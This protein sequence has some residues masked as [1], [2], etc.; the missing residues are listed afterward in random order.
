MGLDFGV[1]VNPEFLRE[2]A[3]LTDF[4]SPD[5][6]V[7]GEFDRKSGD[8]LETLYKEFHRPVIRCT[9]EEAELVKYASNGFLATQISYF[10]EVHALCEKLGL[11]SQVVSQA[12]SLDMRIGRYGVEGG[13]PFDGRCLP[14]DIEAFLSYAQRVGAT[15]HV[16]AVQRESTRRLL[17]NVW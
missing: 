2:N 3:A 15:L 7:I 8:E 10:N 9:P 11:D 13:R 14:K 16:L 12:V 1:C 4:L 17:S 5:R 6:I